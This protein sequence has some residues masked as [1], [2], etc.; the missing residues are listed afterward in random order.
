VYL[1]SILNDFGF[2]QVSPTLLYED[3]RAVIVMVE[4]PVN[5]K[6]SRHID[7]RKH[8]IGQLV[9]I[10]SHQPKHLHLVDIISHTHN[11]SR[12]QTLPARTL[13]LVS[14]QCAHLSVRHMLQVSMQFVLRKT[15]ARI[16]LDRFLRRNINPRH[17][18]ARRQ[19]A[20]VNLDGSLH[21]GKLKSL[22]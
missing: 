18:A 2:E 21:S 16:R 19:Q 3:S 9:D 13:T 6:A 4:N 15:E 12:E 5:R 17:S 8:L 14:K 22:Q 10:N 1:R 11:M 20:T 7:T